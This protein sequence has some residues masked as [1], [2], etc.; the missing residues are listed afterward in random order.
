M[1]EAVELC[2]NTDLLLVVDYFLLAIWKQGTH[3]INSQ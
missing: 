3:Y 2:S 1:S